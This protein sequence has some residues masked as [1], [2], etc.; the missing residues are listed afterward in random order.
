MYASG[1]PF[2][3]LI[4]TKGPRWA[5]LIGSIA[6]ACGY[7]P[8][9][10]AYNKGPGSMGTS[11]L[12]FFSFLTGMGSCSAFAGSIKV[13]ATNWPHHRGTA[14]AF[15]LSGFGLSAFIFTLIGSFAFPNDAGDYLLMLAVGT[16]VMVF[17]GMFFMNLHPP[18]SYQPLATEDGS[19]RPVYPRKN[20]TRSTLPGEPG[21]SHVSIPPLRSPISCFLRFSRKTAPNSSLQALMMPNPMRLP[22]SSPALNRACPTSPRS[23]Q[24]LTHTKKILQDGLSQRVVPFGNCS[25]CLA[26]FVVLG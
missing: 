5:I 19:G 14:T 18:S 16:F 21:K 12:C 17:T 24:R 20:S 22:L 6:L 2:G 9:Y 13:S 11:A 8:L 23:N 10:S 7:F 1:I 15:P 3:I 26:C 25:F 4:D